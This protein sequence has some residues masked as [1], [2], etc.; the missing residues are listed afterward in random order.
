MNRDGLKRAAARAALDYIQPGM[1][2][3]VGTGS[4][5][6]YF[7]DGLAELKDRIEGTVASS[8]ASAERLERHGIPVL[9]LNEVGSCLST[10]TGRM[11]PTPIS[12]SSRAAEDH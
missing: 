7:I 4:T 6:D 3:G 9:E 12:G 10:L 5:T 8:L 11:R 2:V 1:I